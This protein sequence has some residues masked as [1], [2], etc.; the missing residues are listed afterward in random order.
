[1]NNRYYIDM[2]VR[3]VEAKDKAILNAIADQLSDCE[4]AKRILRMK[5]YGTSGMTAAASANLVDRTKGT[6]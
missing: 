5:G 4:D 6:R 1:M 3:A 2:V